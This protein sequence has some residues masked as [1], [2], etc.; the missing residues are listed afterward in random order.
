MGP[1]A[2]DRLSHESRQ[3]CLANSKPATARGGDCGE[4]AAGKEMGQVSGVV[5]LNAPSASD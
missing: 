2:A 5:V 1:W 3:Q 4:A